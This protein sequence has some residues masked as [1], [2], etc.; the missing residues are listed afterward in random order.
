VHD[1]TY[2]GLPVLGR[3]LDPVLSLNGKPPSTLFIVCWLAG[4]FD[5]LI[6]FNLGTLLGLGLVLGLT[7]PGFVPYAGYFVLWFA[8]LTPML[9]R[10]LFDHGIGVDVVSAARSYPRR[11]AIGRIAGPI[12]IYGALVAFWLP[13]DL[14]RVAELFLL[15]ALVAGAMEMPLYAL[16]VR[17]GRDAWKTLVVNTLF[18]WSLVPPLMYV[19]LSSL[20]EV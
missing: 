4:W 5:F 12:L 20:G 17:Q 16:R 18:E 6:A 11:A 15:G 2:G 13:H 14:T 10:F 1:S 19:A 3:E 9:S 8:L 7:S